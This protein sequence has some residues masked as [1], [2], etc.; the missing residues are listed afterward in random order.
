MSAVANI[1]V[2]VGAPFPSLVKASGPVTLSK[3][4]GIWTV[5][6]SVNGIG[7]MPINVNP[8]TVDILVWNTLTQSWQVATL[9][10]VVTFSNAPT[11]ISSANSP[12]TPLPTDTYLYVDTS[13]GAVEIDLAAAANRNGTSL[14]IKDTTGHAAANNITIKPVGGGAPETLDGY[15]NAAPLVLKANYDAVSLSPNTLSY[16]IDP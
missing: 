12:Y 4:N 1:R 8:V 3:Q 6:L 10:Q 9:S 13:T 11:K 7:G 16:L 5:G 15:T 14:K 2:N